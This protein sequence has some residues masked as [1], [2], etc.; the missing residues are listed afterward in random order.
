MVVWQAC[1]HFETS[2]WARV[3]LLGQN[4]DSVLPRPLFQCPLARTSAG[5]EEEWCGKLA[6]LLRS[7]PR[8]GQDI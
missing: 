6:Y 4:L 2:A 1:I 8:V 7:L 3:L 5:L